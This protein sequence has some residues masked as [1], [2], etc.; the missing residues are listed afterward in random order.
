MSGLFQ[1]PPL[2]APASVDLSAKQYYAISIDTNGELALPAL[3]SLPDGVL[4]TAP[5][6]GKTG[7][8][9]SFRGQRVT[10]IAGGAVTVGALASVLATGKVVI[11]VTSTHIRFGKFLSAGGD[12][13][14]VTVLVGGN[15][16][17]VP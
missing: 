10:M 1:E 9:D 4:M 13:E 7:T 8:Y 5:E 6:A 14:E 17:P 2:Q 15:H 3:G 11:S 12:G 16:A